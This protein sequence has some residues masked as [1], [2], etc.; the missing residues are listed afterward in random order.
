[1]GRWRGALVGLHA[2]DTFG[3][4]DNAV[5]YFVR[6]Y[7]PPFRAIDSAKMLA[8]LNGRV[9]GREEQIVHSRSLVGSGENLRRDFAVP[10]LAGGFNLICVQLESTSALHV[11]RQSAPN[12]M[13]LADHGVSFSHHATTFSET[14]RASYSIYYSDYMPDL[15][16]TPSLVYGKPM[17][18]PTIAEVLQ[19]AG[20]RT[21]L[22]HSGFLDYMDLRYLFHD[23]GFETTV[24]AR[25][26]LARGGGLVS[27]WGVHEEQTVG[28]IMEWVRGHKTER[29]FAAYLTQCPHHP[30]DCP[31]AEQ[32]FGGGTWRDRYR[33]SLHYT[34]ACVGQLVEGLRNEGLLDKTLIVLFGD[35][36]ET[37]S[38]YPVGHGI[39]L[40]AEEVRTPFII[41]NPLLFPTAQVSCMATSHLDIAPTLAAVMGLKAPA[42]WLGRDLTADE[43]PARLQFVNILQ[44]KITAVIDNGLMCGFDAQRNTTQLYELGLNGATALY[45]ERS[46]PGADWPISGAKRAVFGVEH[47]ASFE[48]GG[49]GDAAGLAG[50]S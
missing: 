35:H 13:A 15:G 10:A 39:A 3:I 42:Q 38:T 4:K 7:A 48:A 8:G 47:P 18:Q 6:H 14:S 5:I 46:A 9:E 43:V 32:P 29:F 20:Y 40:S 33:N 21:G 36:G 16:T 31:V 1:M 34:D 45:S 44:A 22:F 26:M 49:V 24:A 19:R 41:S 2:V 12:I 50:T 23:K 30:Y 27:S 11:D 37:V 28:E 25:D 17:P